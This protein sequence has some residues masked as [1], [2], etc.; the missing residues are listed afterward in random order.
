MPIDCSESM[1]SNAY[2]DFIIEYNNDE[3]KLRNY[4]REDC[5]SIINQ[6]FAVVSSRRIRAGNDLRPRD[7]QIP[8]SLTPKCYGIMDSTS[9][10][11]SGIKQTIDSDVYGYTGLG[12][13]ICIIDTGIDYQSPVFINEDGTSR[14][15]AIWDQTIRNGTA[16]EP[17]GYGSFYTN[18]QINEALLSDNPLFLVPS[19]DTNGHGTFLASIAA[20]NEVEADDFQGAAP[21]A[22]IVVVKLKPA[23]A[24]LKWLY[25][26]P[27]E[28]IAFQENDIMAG[29][30][31][32]IN[33]AKDLDRPL[34]ICIGLGTSSGSHEGLGALSRM[35]SYV[36]G[37]PEV[38]VCTALGNEGSERLHAEGTGAQQV[39]EFNVGE[40][41]NILSM[42]LW[43]R[44]PDIYAV[45][46]ETPDGTVIER[47]PPR[48]NNTERIDFAVGGTVLYVEYT[49][50]EFMSGDELI[51]I[52]LYRPT[53][54][55]WKLYV[56]AEGTPSPYFHIWMP[57]RSFV[58]R[59]TYF[60][61]ASSSTTLTDPS[62]GENVTSVTAY[63]HLQGSI[64]IQASRGYTA[65]DRVKP[66]LAAP[67]VEVFGMGLRGIYERR[68]GTSVAAA[69][70][71]G[72]AAIIEQWGRENTERRFTGIQIKRYLINGANRMSNEQWPNPTWGWGKLDLL[73]VFEMLRRSV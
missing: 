36:S 45:G 20:G 41:Q 66:D 53:P 17:F 1:Y 15:V 67:G 51:F 19:E 6:T 58:S 43:G 14:I 38:F 64:S 44:A 32:A 39:I 59:D 4:F 68:S 71:A 37:I 3:E 7:E 61:N 52:W 31:F 57:I 55:P 62:D 49:L 65:D 8:Y 60:L 2:A 5:I 46:F 56:Y 35:V 28:S 54:G 22:G 18:V 42:E 69:H 24:Y 12:S 50:A 40:S 16:P 63:D 9:M 47:I 72:A 34:S 25:G 27:E 73:Q 29:V 11:A 70:V 21:E 30:A 10:E 23:K 48:F 26:I 13:L 33:L